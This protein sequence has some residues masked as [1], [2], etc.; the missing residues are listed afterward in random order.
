[1]SRAARGCQPLERPVSGPARI[2]E[3]SRMSLRHVVGLLSRPKAEWGAIRERRY[4]V[5]RSLVTHT[6]VLALIPAIAAM[7]GVHGTETFEEM[8][9]AAD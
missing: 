6:A 3:A 9:D 4:G 5:G 1:M 7:S 2:G 8:P